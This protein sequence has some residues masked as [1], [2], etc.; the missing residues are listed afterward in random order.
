MKEKIKK[1][2]S[3]RTIKT[4][5]AS[6]LALFVAG[7]LGL[8]HFATAGIVALLSI[9]PT[10]RKSIAIAGQRFLA[11]LLAMAIGLLIFEIFGYYFFMVGIYFIVAIP[12]LVKLKLQEGLVV[13]SVMLLQLYVLENSSWQLIFN[14]IAVVAVGLGLALLVNLFMPNMTKDLEFDKD[15]SEVYFRAILAELVLQLRQQEVASL[16]AIINSL[17]QV[18][19]EGIGLAHIEL[20]NSLRKKKS[21][22]L[23]YFEMRR[24][25]F[26]ILKERILP[27][28]ERIQGQYHQGQMI[29]EFLERI[30]GEFE[31]SNPVDEIL[32]ALS[33]MNVIFREM[34]LPQTRREFETR[35]ALLSLVNELESFLVLKQEFSFQTK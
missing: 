11:C 1:T 27:L 16:D 14:Q 31:E 9:Q 24:K 13:S 20:G 7:Q 28:V 25:Q 22:Y 30:A 35:A 29:A 21:Y 15:K 34:D 12:I 19:E 26:H 33:D 8:A 6:S 2:F 23:S 4:A 17:E 10:K 5:V 18:I 32:K 3:Y